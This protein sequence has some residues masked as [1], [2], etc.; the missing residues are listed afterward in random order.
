MNRT[1]GSTPPNPTP[2]LPICSTDLNKTLGIVGTPHGYSIDKLWSTKTRRI[3]AKNTPNPRTM[4][5]PQSSPFSHGFG[6]RINGKRTT[7]GSCIHPPTNPQENGLKTSPKNRHKK[8]LK[9]TK[10]ENREELKQALRNH[11]ESSINTMKVHTSSSLLPDHP[12]L[13]QDLTMKLSS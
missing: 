8:A 10:K 13:S 2:D 12:S 1:R 3:S 6:R 5:T 4:K 7:K 9:I 11:A